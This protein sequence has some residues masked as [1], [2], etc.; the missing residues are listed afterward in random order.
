MEA[1]SSAHHWG[2]CFERIGHHVLLLPP[3]DVAKYRKGQK[4]DRTDAK[5]LLEAHRNE[6]ICPVPIKSTDQLAMTSLH[7]LRSRWMA[8]RT[9][10]LNTIR[11]L[12]REFGCHIP[13]GA[14]H[15][16]P[17]VTAW[18]DDGSI[19]PALAPILRDALDEIRDLE[20]R[21]R[22]LETQL[23]VLAK[24][25]DDVRRLRSVPGIGLLTA[26][27]LVAFVGSPQRFPTG[28]CFA[29]FLGLVPKEFSSGHIRRRGS[30]PKRGDIYLRTLLIHGARAVLCHAKKTENPDGL[31]AWALET[32]KRR[33][34]NVAAVA[35]ANKMA[36][37]AWAT[38]KREEDYH[39]TSNH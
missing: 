17:Q 35:L 18:L 4:T 34:H 36:R 23:E 12:L 29:S 26:T 5:A 14:S 24:G 8:S 39:T 32:E 30:I 37:I 31:R 9:A 25:M 13:V 16:L 3:H 11:G 33:G 27:A 38:W 20:A 10:G 7:R 28:R 22:R 1:C 2:R 21:I 6:E 19:H 15:V